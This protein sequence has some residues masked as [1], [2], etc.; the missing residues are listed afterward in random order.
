MDMFV[1]GGGCR[2]EGE[3]SISG[4]KNSSLPLIAAVLLAEGQSVLTNVPDLS[5]IRT[6]INLLNCLGVQSNYENDKLTLERDSIPV[7]DNAPSS[8]K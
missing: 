4:S 5:D 6:M 2:L 3:V 7:Q 8:N 1:V